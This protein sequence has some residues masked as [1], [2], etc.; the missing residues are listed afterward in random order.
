MVGN[1]T[2]ENF[3][4]GTELIINTAA[5]RT[6]AAFLFLHFLIPFF[7]H[8]SPFTSSGTSSPP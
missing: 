8:R 2:I 3:V 7:L 5:S 4:F 1:A 6:D